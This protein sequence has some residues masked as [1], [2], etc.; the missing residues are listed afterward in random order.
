MVFKRGNLTMKEMRKIDQFEIS[1][2][3]NLAEDC[4]IGKLI[5]TDV[6]T[7]T[8]TDSCNVF[9]D[10]I[11][12]TNSLYTKLTT[13]SCCPIGILPDR[14][15]EE[16]AKAIEVNLHIHD[17][18]L[19]VNSVFSIYSKGFDGIDGEDGAD[20]GNGGVGQ[21]ATQI[22]ESDKSCFARGGN[23]GDGGNG[24]N[25]T[26]GSDGGKAPIL[27]ITC[28]N[29]VK[30]KIEIFG[31]VSHGSTGGRGGR[32]GIGGKGGKGGLDSNGG[33][34]SYDGKDGKT[35]QKGQDGKSYESIRIV[36]HINNVDKKDGEEDV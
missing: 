27:T 24:G 15:D 33:K 30:E 13:P 11:D 17:I 6:G 19:D 5:F 23:G 2:A 3:Q 9:I 8:I 22:G 4:A 14:S 10:T 34:K 35:G 16:E 36:W 25:G 32:A 1:E 28:T 26:A 29:E 12:L 20:G 18:L 31:G 21:D 7:L